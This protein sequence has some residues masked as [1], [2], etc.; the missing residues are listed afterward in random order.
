MY[1]I[2]LTSVR[3]SHTRAYRYEFY[4][5]LAILNRQ[6]KTFIRRSDM[7]KIKLFLLTCEGFPT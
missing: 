6:V 4:F 2:G 1:W 3:I 7:F 5:K